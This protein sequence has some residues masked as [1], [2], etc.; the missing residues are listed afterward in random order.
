MIMPPNN[1]RFTKKT[2][3]TVSR[4][5]C[6]SCREKKIKCDG[7]QVCRNCQQ[8]NIECVFVKSHR[9]GRR[10]SKQ[11]DP[12]TTNTTEN[13]TN[14][15][16]NIF[17]KQEKQQQHQP[18]NIMSA[19]TSSSIPSSLSL[20][21]L[22]DLRPEPYPTSSP[23]Q[24]PP[25]PH[26]Y[27]HPIPTTRQQIE[28]SNDQSS[29]V[30]QLEQKI[31]LLQD[32]IDELTKTSPAN[33]N[34][35]ID[36]NGMKSLDLPDEPLATHMIDLYYTHV[37]PNH[38]F[39]F[40]RS[41]FFKYLSI[42]N[43]VSLVHAIMS[44]SCRYLSHQD[45][46]IKPY[47]REPDYWLSNCEK[48]MDTLT[49]SNQAKTLLLCSISTMFNLDFEQAGSFIQKTKSLI[50][51]HRLHKRHQRRTLTKDLSSSGTTRGDDQQRSLDIANR[52]QLIDRESL[53]RTIWHSWKI[54]LW[55]AIFGK[56]NLNHSF[57]SAL[58]LP[59][60]T[61]Y[62]DDALKNWKPT[63]SFWD[64][65]ETDLLASSKSL[66]ISPLFYDMAFLI[67]AC[68]LAGS[69][70]RQVSDDP[71]EES[72]YLS[73]DERR[74]QLSV[75]NSILSRSR[76]IYDLIPQSDIFSP[77]NMSTICILYLST[78][79]LNGPVVSEAMIFVSK[80]LSYYPIN[81]NL[82]HSGVYWV[83]SPNDA[84]QALYNHNAQYS[85]SAQIAEAY[86]HCLWVV[87]G[88]TKFLVLPSSSSTT[89]LE[90]WESL[91]QVFINL[92]EFT[93]AFLGTQIILNNFILTHHQQEGEKQQLFSTDKS[94]NDK[95]LSDLNTCLSFINHH[96]SIFPPYKQISSRIFWIFNE[97]NRLVNGI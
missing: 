61:V 22:A 44:I 63:L 15:N 53:I 59:V 16:Q 79:M 77:I 54:E 28:P 27:N 37:H 30:S 8:L 52:F 12:A 58:C 42:K 56:I 24:P 48:Y 35:E 96:A 14:T 49:E 87:D 32:R 82:S 74:M 3:R 41:V 2:T 57:D 91:P 94:N 45:S 84:Y 68:Q 70:T 5:A 80:T 29:I 25:P 40:P 90:Y 85:T 38:P 50:H 73:E 64:Q 51:L 1:E 76:K 86:S 34:W 9:G 20:P 4:R 7:V 23:R 66:K 13:T 6:L 62:Y 39:L 43:D 55:L 46:S 18:S 81:P 67:S 72:K 19:S 69:T 97:V 95:L 92:L 10:N 83:R 89:K 93:V 26:L 36:Q 78:I 21:S 75:K 71:E 33:N 60:S 88:I 11:H 47:M 31:A 17:M 65:F